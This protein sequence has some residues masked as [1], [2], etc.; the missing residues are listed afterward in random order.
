MALMIEMHRHMLRG[1]DPFPEVIEQLARF[2][3]PEVA[4]AHQHLTSVV[5]PRS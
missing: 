3:D 2:E 4:G 1:I 5:T